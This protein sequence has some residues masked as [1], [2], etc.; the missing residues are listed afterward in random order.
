MSGVGAAR[1]AGWQPLEVPAPEETCDGLCRYVEHTIGWLG[2]VA[3]A[4]F[5]ALE[6]Q[7]I[8]FPWKPGQGAGGRD[9]FFAFVVPNVYFHVTAVYLILRGNGLDVGK[10]DFLGVLPFVDA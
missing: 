4:D 6:S 7:T 9:H 10:A 1:L 5:L 3:E 2:G 8:T